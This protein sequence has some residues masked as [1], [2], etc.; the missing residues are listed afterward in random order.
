MPLVKGRPRHSLAYNISFILGGFGL[1]AIA[2]PFYP[3][4]FR[5]AFIFPFLFG[6]GLWVGGVLFRFIGWEES[7]P[8]IKSIVD[9]ITDGIGIAALLITIAHF[10][11]GLPVSAPAL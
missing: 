3:L 5:I 9:G 1:W 4:W 8:S 10:Y 6:T 11:L 2:F 7:F